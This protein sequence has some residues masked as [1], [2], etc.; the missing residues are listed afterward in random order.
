ME[1]GS[2]SLALD[3]EKIRSC[4]PVTFHPQVALIAHGELSDILVC[5][6]VQYNKHRPQIREPGRVHNQE[7]LHLNQSL[8][9]LRIEHPTYVIMKRSAY[10][11]LQALHQVKM[12]SNYSFDLYRIKNTRLRLAGGYAPRPPK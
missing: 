11:V 7:E 6:T 2:R 4:T 12:S 3:D 10:R 1:T 9:V 8:E 5:L